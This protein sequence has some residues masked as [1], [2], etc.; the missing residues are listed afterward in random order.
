MLSLNIFGNLTLPQ[1]MLHIA[2]NETERKSLGFINV[3]FSVFV[4]AIDKIKG[5]KDIK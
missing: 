3:Y 1:M 5:I 4:I 2:K